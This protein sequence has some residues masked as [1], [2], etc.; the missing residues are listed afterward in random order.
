MLKL[1][2]RTMRLWLLLALLSNLIWP[3]DS[4]AGPLYDSLLPIQKSYW[5]KLLHYH[6]DKS[7]ADGEYFFLSPHGKTNPEEEMLADISAFNDPNG[8]AGWFHYHPQCVFKER[9]SFLKKAGFLKDTKIVNC[10][11]FDEW[12]KGLNPESITL[13][14]SSSYPNNPSSLFGHTLIRISQKN[15]SSQTAYDL[16]DYSFAFSAMPEKEDIG[17][18][19]AYKGFF[20]GYKG[21]LEVTKYYSK[22]AE[23]NDGESRDLIEYNLKMSPDELDSLVNHL[24]EIYQTTYFDYYFAD[25]NC[26]A[27]LADIL[28]VA[29]HLEDINT[30]QRWYYLP[31]EMVKSFRRV[32]DLI[33]SESYRPSLKKQLEKKISL[34]TNAQKNDLKNLVSTKNLPENYDQTIVLDAIIQYLDFTRYRTKNQLTDK[35]KILLRKSLLKRAALGEAVGPELLNYDQ[36][37]R[38]DYGHEPKKLSY[39]LR[40][41]KSHSLIGLELKQGYHD[42]MS[43]DLGFDAFSQ[44]DFLVGSLLF[45]K[46]LNKISYDNLTL[47]NLTSLH[48]YSFYDPQFS[49]SAKVV[50][51]RIYDLDCDLCHKVGARAY[52]GPTLKP[53]NSIAMT[54]MA[55]VFAEAS[56]HFE[57]GHRAGVGAEASLYW[58]A[59]SKYKVGFSDEI[60][61]DASRKIKRDF[62]NRIQLL[63]SYFPSI[64]SEWRFE[65]AL[66]SKK[67]SLNANIWVNQLA[68]GIYY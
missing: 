20:G 50:A 52:F 54:L 36:S 25:E 23:Y 29:Y 24:W 43:N 14:F 41:E 45:D 39:F 11:E 22:V 34:L 17:V 63:N 64:N 44:F 18:V 13:V 46:Q 48:T 49:W 60:R 37:N 42:L 51:D 2:L 30:H 66:H 67:G 26:S 33:V 1:K 7:R 57:K 5:L 47:V 21:L 68:Y 65:S 56:K 10:T 53:E 62:S 31:S 4:S 15:K 3:A 55:G 40:S 19:F 12:K 32:P 35:E 61:F 16:I 8:K 28:A 9:F 58:Q 6:N 27:V 59:A 38:P